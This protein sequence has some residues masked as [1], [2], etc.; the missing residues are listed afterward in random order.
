M[1]KTPAGWPRISSAGPLSGRLSFVVRTPKAFDPG[2]VF[3]RTQHHAAT[4]PSDVRAACHAQF[5]L[6]GN[7]RALSATGN[8]VRIVY[9]TGVRHE[10]SNDPF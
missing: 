1:K 5:I 10:A 9:I 2:P 8:I 6:D 3:G 4:E 7:A